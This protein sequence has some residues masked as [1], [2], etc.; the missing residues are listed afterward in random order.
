MDRVELVRLL[1]LKSIADDYENVDQVILREVADNLSKLGLVIER[2]EVV[3]ALSRLVEDGLAKAYLL[4]AREP[5]STELQ[6]MPALDLVEEDFKTYFYVTQ[7][8]KDVLLSD[9]TV[10]PFD[11]DGNPL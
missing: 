8:G 10:W 1:V 5:Y 3:D 4:S 6:G 2:P 9:R 7:Q 11:E